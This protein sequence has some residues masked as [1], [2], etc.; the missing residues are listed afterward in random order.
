M[1]LAIKKYGEAS[2]IANQTVLRYAIILTKVPSMEE[3]SYKVFE[4]AE[5][6]FDVIF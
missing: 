4:R 2:F 5:S 6:M 3:E 1:E